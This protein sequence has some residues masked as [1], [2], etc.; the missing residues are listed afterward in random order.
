MKS[1]QRIAVAWLLLFFLSLSCAS[2]KMLATRELLQLDCSV[3]LQ[4]ELLSLN[5]TAFEGGLTVFNNKQVGFHSL[6]VSGL[7][8]VPQD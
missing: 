3:A 1:S 6:Y 5:A 4:Y 2:R 8:K 7:A